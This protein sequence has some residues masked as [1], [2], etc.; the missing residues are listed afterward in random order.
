MKKQTYKTQ[1]TSFF[2]IKKISKK[3]KLKKNK[4]FLIKVTNKMSQNK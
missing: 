3:V 1:K 2:A 4:W